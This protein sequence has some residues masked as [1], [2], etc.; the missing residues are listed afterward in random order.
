[1]IDRDL[2]DD[3][4]ELCLSGDRCENPFCPEYWEALLYEGAPLEL[5]DAG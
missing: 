5:E 4:D 1:M 3:N 2:E